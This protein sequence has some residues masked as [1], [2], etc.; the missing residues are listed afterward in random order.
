MSQGESLTDVLAKAI[1]NRLA[2]LYTALPA[3][4]TSYDFRTQKASV[5][6]TIR[7]RYADGRIEP[8]PVINNVPVIFPRA[9]GASLTFPVKPGDTV[10]LIFA[11]RSL[12]TWANSGGT[13]DQD[14]NRMH[15]L[16]DAI[17]IPGLIPFS[18]RSKAKNNDD[19][20]LTYKG[21]EIEIKGNGNIN[22]K[23]PKVRIDSPE[24]RMTGDL[25]VEQDIFDQNTLYG[26]FGGFRNLYNIHTHNENDAAPG[27]T[28]ETNHP[29]GVVE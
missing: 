29:W 14:D 4:I 15:D 24:V 23:A 27:P 13:V 1:R 7:R 8:Y 20:L 21:T 18:A 12:D 6:P 17:A 28:E 19:V 11:S 26:S 5:K 16:N 9:G 3:E 25:I 10:L 22:M 2:E